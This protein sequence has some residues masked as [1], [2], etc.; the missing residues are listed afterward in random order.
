MQKLQKRIKPQDEEAKLG[1]HPFQ[2]F[3]R[4]NSLGK[5][6]EARTLN[7]RKQVSLFPFTCLL[8]CFCVVVCLSASGNCIFRYMYK[9]EFSRILEVSWRN[10]A[11]IGRRAQWSSLLGCE[12]AE[13]NS[14]PESIMPLSQRILEILYQRMLLQPL[15]RVA[16]LQSKLC[17]RD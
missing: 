17:S 5:S 15:S 11:G 4:R 8:A 14:S 6:Y 1:I 16:I 10:L 3:L 12:R 2:E 9:T 13:M 7:D